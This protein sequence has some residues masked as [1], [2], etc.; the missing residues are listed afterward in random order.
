MSSNSKILL[1]QKSEHHAANIAPKHSLH[2]FTILMGIKKKL[3]N[4]KGYWGQIKQVERDAK[5]IDA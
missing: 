1:S 2:R 3:Q 4:E 5:S